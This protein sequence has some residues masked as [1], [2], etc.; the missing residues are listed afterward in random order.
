[1]TVSATKNP[2]TLDNPTKTLQPNHQKE[3]ELTK[4][5]NSLPPASPKNPLTEYPTSRTA[6]TSVFR[7]S[8]TREATIEKLSKKSGMLT[9]KSSKC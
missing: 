9:G 5:D 7:N 3:K 4:L 2:L 8:P 1:M 6:S